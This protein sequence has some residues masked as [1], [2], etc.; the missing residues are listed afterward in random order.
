[1]EDWKPP[2]LHSYDTIQLITNEEGE[3]LPVGF[4][5][6]GMTRRIKRDSLLSQMKTR[7]QTLGVPP[8]M[9]VCITMYNEDVSE[10]K[11]TLSGAIQNYN[12]LCND[13]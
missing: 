11:Q 2:A 7:C 8:K 10:L 12:E 4:G 5:H 13:P 3:V 6:N 9:A 1:M